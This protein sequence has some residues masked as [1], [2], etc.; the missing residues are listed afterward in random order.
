MPEHPSDLDSQKL[1]NLADSWGIQVEY[2]DF[3]ETPSTLP[4]A[5]LVA[6]LG[7][8][9]VEIETSTQLDAALDAE[10]ER[11]WARALPPLLPATEGQPA[12][13]DA[14]V[15][16]EER[17]QIVL[18]AGGTVEPSGGPEILD[19]GTVVTDGRA[20]VRQLLRFTFPALPIGW[21]RVRLGSAVAPVA[22]APARLAPPPRQWGV[23]AQLY[24]V[25]SRASWGIGD[26][27]DL[28]DLA[29]T[30]AGRG[31]DFLLINPVHAAAPVP[32]VENSPYLPSSRVAVNP[33]YVRIQDVPEIGYLHPDEQQLI[34]TLSRNHSGR[35][36]STELLERDRTM[37][38]VVASLRLLFD[39]PMS[40]TRTSE[41]RDFV[42]EG[43]PAL[44]RWAVWAAITEY[45]AGPNLP[46]R[47]RKRWATG[48]DHAGDEKVEEFA[49]EHGADVEFWMWVQFI[50][51]EQLARA[52]GEARRGGMA[53]GIVHD[54]AV[55]VASDGADAWALGDVLV[56]GASV[57][58]PADMYNQLGQDWSQPPLHPRK[59]A[60]AGYQ[61]LVDMC[62]RVFR[63]S[64]GVRIDHIMGLFRLWWIPRGGSPAN[65][66]YVRYDYRAMLT[67][68]TLE[69][70]L[71][72][73]HVIG[74][75]LGTVE[76][77]VRDELGARGI[78][79]T[80]V[81][82]FENPPEGPRDPADYREGTLATLNTHDM[83]PLGGYLAL[84]DVDLWERLGLL[85]RDASLV[86][87][88]ERA[89]RG[90]VVDA[91][92]GL[93]LLDSAE[94]ADW[95]AGGEAWPIV[96]A[97]HRWLAR[98]KA[99]LVG[100][101]LT[102]IVGE[103]RAQN[104]PGTSDEYPNWRI[105]LADDD[106]NAVLVESLGNNRRL[107]AIAAVMNSGTLDR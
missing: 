15:A 25:R 27:A 45:L 11:R 5:T 107:D 89:N 88:E 84:E 91:L 38:D 95:R 60:E 56:R 3:T 70:H 73:V 93:G 61:P 101:S 51:D 65:G 105:P 35:V 43:G 22:V 13:L 7:T 36:V 66:G 20:E 104:Q 103:A 72:G 30:L 46:R 100:V 29:V 71:A 78:L 32:P 63:H 34:E 58:A 85:S 42:A 41:F 12:V 68:L 90:R 4:D 18:A 28:R 82:W 44:R 40:T 2:Q 53:T 6:L 55:G 39:V 59:L 17:P 83:S 49:A 102:D 76:P 80:T 23:A 14:V 47:F 87:E 9:G 19:T 98:S 96:L 33:L 79:G 62:R 69:A 52:Q 99:R 75:D 1:R 97:L 21:H 26:F 48:L 92:V 10:R 64:G 86:R 54:L 57:G 94:A 74:E 8:L 24:S 50:I 37:R 16:G 77:W 67:V 81:A 106:G 31:A